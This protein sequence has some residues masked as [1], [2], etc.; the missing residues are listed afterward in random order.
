[1]FV[2]FHCLSL[3]TVFR[4]A[5]TFQ[6]LG[7]VHKYKH[8]ACLQIFFSICKDVSSFKEYCVYV[9]VYTP[10]N[11]LKQIKPLLSFC[12]YLGN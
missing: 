7:K 6:I 2:C 12:G 5:R 4:E 8:L 1:M 3:N 9:Y 11:M 10:Q